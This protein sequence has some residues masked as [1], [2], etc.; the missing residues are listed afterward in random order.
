MNM[1][2]LGDKVQVEGLDGDWFE[3]VDINVFKH[4]SIDGLNDYHETTYGGINVNDVEDYLEID[5]NE[6]TDVQRKGSK[7]DNLLDQ[8]NNL[9]ELNAV[10]CNAFA[11]EYEQVLNELK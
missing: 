3:I 5:E 8:L 9:K 11:D 2:N 10:T 7:I 4:M 1:Y 6:I